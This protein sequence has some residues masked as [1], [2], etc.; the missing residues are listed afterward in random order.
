MLAIARTRATVSVGGRLRAKSQQ[1]EKRR[2][3]SKERHVAIGFS[4]S[5]PFKGS[6][7]GCWNECSEVGE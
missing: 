6:I 3:E 7:C 1:A 5:D 4:D 2:R